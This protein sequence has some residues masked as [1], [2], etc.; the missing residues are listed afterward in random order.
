MKVIVLVSGG[1]DSVAALYHSADQHEVVQQLTGAMFQ[2]AGTILETVWPVLLLVIGVSLLGRFLRS[3]KVKGRVGEAIVS[4]G[5]LKRLD[6]KVYRIFND[7][8]LPRPD[9]KGTTQIDHVVVSPFGI[10]VVETKNY[11]GWIFGDEDSRHWTQVICGKKSRFQNPLH[12]N[13]LHVNALAKATGLPRHL[14]HNLV[15]FVGEA[16]LKTPLPPQVMTGG[17]ASHIRGYRMEAIAPKDV[18]WAVAILEAA[19]LAEPAQRRAHQSRF[20]VATGS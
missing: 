15:Y 2:T 20:R 5:A 7:I 18:S 17:L 4:L 8:V 13:A 1:M 3:A 12:Q 14:F 19:A 10:F 9:G 16:T 6:S 11:A